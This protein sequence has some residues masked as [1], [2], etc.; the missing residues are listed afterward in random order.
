MELEARKTSGCTA[1]GPTS[2]PNF[3][4]SPKSATRKSP[5]KNNYS[6]IHP[7]TPPVMSPKTTSAAPTKRRKTSHDSAVPVTSDPSLKKKSKL[8]KPAFPSPTSDDDNSDDGAE[9]DSPA[10]ETTESTTDNAVATTKTAPETTEASAPKTFKD[11]VSPSSDDSLSLSPDRAKAHVNLQG[12]M[13]ALCEAC[14][15]L[16]FKHP[17]PIQC[18]SIPVA[19]SGKDMIGLAETG[20]GKTAAFA[21]PIL[22]ALWDSPT[23][24]F[25]CVLAPTREL[26]FQI[27]EQ[28]EALG[29]TIGVR[30]AVIVGGMNNVE[31]AVALGKKP[32]VV[33]ATP[34]RLLDHL[35]NTKG[36]SLRNLKYLVMDEADR[37][38]D[39]DFG[40][41]IDKILKVIPKQRNTYLFSATMTSKVEK[42][43]RASLNSPVKVSV[44]SKYATVSTLI[45]RLLFIPFMH[46]DV[47]LVYL[48]NEFAG[49]TMLVFARTVVET[50]RLAL[51]LRELGFKA[52]PLNGQMSQSARL[53]S[54]NKFKNGSRN[55]LIATDVAARGL[56]MF[57]T[58]LYTHNSFI[59]I[60]LGITHELT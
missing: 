14:A 54:L 36:F 58:P 56:D 41:V 19:L 12:V 40:P 32:H 55:I 22:Q 44:S 50:N 47:Y 11:L 37:L 23:G 3:F 57:V 34:G 31:Q 15:N 46:K 28:F 26:A 51:L 6:T 9:S 30:C 8:A 52:I 16:N 17:T 53:G 13:D 18:E 29:S 24:L 43:Q 38:L 59:T 39:M 7:S 48:I 10:Q 4:S 25:A 35:E 1:H 27:S 42:L 2:R 45:Q 5:A 21:L 60:M 20:S 49:Q 33:I